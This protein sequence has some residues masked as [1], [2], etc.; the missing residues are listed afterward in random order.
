MVPALK[1]PGKYALVFVTFSGPHVGIDEALPAGK[2]L[3][4]EF[5]HLGFDVKG[6]WYIV[7]EFHGWKTGSTRGKMGDIRGRPNTEDL[8]RIEKKAARLAKSLK[9]PGQHTSEVMWTVT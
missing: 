3:V 7:G 5:E 8:A 2:Y 4:Q 6:E 1:I 9:S